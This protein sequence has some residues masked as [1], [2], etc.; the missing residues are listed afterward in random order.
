MT[1]NSLGDNNFLPEEIHNSAKPKKRKRKWLLIIALLTV[2]CCFVFVVS[3]VLTPSTSKDTIP[4]AT[5]EVKA[6]SIPPTET[7]IIEPT[8]KEESEYVSDVLDLSQGC[9]DAMNEIGELSTSVG[10]NPALIL[11]EEWKLNVTL[12]LLKINSSCVELGNLSPP[13]KFNEADKYFKLAAKD[14]QS[15]INSYFVALEDLDNGD[16]DSAISSLEEAT[17]YILSG[18]DFYKIAMAKLESE[19]D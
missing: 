14:Y 5:V 2:I 1:Q 7:P 12:A 15:M 8:N 17:A 3:S 19:S 9:V 10:E 11:S 6:T 4:S 18:T 16:A 13:E